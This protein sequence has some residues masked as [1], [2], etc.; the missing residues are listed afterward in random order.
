MTPTAIRESQVTAALDQFGRVLD[1][2]CAVYGP[3]SS[4]TLDGHSAPEKARKRGRESLP[5]RVARGNGGSPAP[6]EALINARG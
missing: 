4:G 6:V 3:G 5:L 2:V 1:Q